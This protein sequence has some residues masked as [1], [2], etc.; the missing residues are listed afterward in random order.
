VSGACSNIRGM[1]KHIVLWKLKG[2]AEGAERDENARI[3]A[4]RL[5]A[6]AGAIPEIRRIEV[7][8]NIATA[9]G[10]YDVA[11]YS[12]FASREDLAVYQRHPAH[13]EVAGFIARV[14][15]SRAVVDYEATEDRNP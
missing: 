11:L 5:Q 12:E 8:F 3:I 6:L 13:Q 1:I 7:G 2:C 9:E 14:R 10:A 4:A 15:E